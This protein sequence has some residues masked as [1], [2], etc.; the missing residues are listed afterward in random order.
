MGKRLV[1]A[2]VVAVG[3][4][5]K[6]I[7]VGDQ[8]LFEPEVDAL[9]GAVESLLCARVADGNKRRQTRGVSGLPRFGDH[10]GADP[11]GESPEKFAARVKAE[12]ASWREVAKAA[13]IEPE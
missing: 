1:W 4:N 10:F 6:T 3:P 7:E 5:V 12:I 2:T 11:G 13:G 8:V 9:L